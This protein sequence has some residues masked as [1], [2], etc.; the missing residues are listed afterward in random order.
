MNIKTNVKKVASPIIKRT[1]FPL[2]V[3]WACTVHKVRGLSLNQVVISFDLLKQK[4]FNHGQIYVTLSR[5]T[6]LDG[7]FLVGNFNEAA[8][9]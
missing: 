9:S 3:S 7:L 6:S 4:Y 1:Q 8:I 5:I 2:S